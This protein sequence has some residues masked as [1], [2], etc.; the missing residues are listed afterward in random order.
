MAHKVLLASGKRDHGPHF[1]GLRLALSVYS[2]CLF[3]HKPL[4]ANAVIEHF[5]IGRRLAFDAAKGRLWVV[6]KSCER[7]NLSPLET[8]W[9]AIEECEKA[10]LGTQLRVSTD[11]IGLA[12]L[13]EGLE[14]VRI[15]APARS[16]FAAWRYGDQ[17]GRRRR[18]AI[19]I[20]GGVAIA[21]GALA[22]AGAAAGVGLGG[23]WGNIPQLLNAMRTVKVRTDD[24]ELIK[25]RG[26]QFNRITLA[27]DP[28]G[29][30]LLG[31]KAQ[32]R[33]WLFRGPEALKLAGQLLPALNYAGGNK[34]AVSYAVMAIEARRG[35][36]GFLAKALPEAGYRFDPSDKRTALSKL[37]APTRLALE[38]ALHE[39]TERRAIEGELE[40]LLD[41]WRE[42]E[43][44]AGIADNLTL[45]P[46]V[47]QRFEA[48]KDEATRKEPE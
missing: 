43:E 23:I 34:T 31:L 19:Y 10:F 13:P 2:T 28:D 40:L 24:G 15:G 33:S 38:M 37:K 47:E 41:A 1:D 16:E 9:E 12:R 7:W 11:N 39:E 22:I 30:A 6:C 26:S 5:P 25:V 17:F 8:R 45:P 14:L 27:R 46:S 48:M 29:T 3:C 36:E 4:G 44:I 18:R 35:P 42:A 21:M 20:G 32:S